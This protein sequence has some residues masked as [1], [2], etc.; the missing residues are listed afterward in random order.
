VGKPVGKI[1]LGKPRHRWVDNI[2]MDHRKIGRGDMGWIDLAQDRDQWRV[3]VNTVMDLRVP[4][5]V[6]KLLN[7]RTSGGFS[8]R[9]LLHEVSL[10][11]FVLFSEGMLN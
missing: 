5:K 7:S 9:V 2:K 6:G 4:Y 3:L 8:R 1:P 10:F 11:C